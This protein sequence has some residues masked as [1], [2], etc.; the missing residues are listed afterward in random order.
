MGVR[1][2]AEPHI[3]KR[4]ETQVKHKVFSYNMPGSGWAI[5]SKSYGRILLLH[6]HLL[7]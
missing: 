7:R 4:R 5:F 2:L 3:A 6:G 1:F